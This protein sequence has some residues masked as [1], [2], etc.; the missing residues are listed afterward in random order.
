MTNSTVQPVLEVK[1]LKQ[2]FTSGFG[3]RKTVLKAVDDV[4][5]TIHKGETFGLVGESGCGKT[6]TG[7]TII[8]LYQ[9]TGGEIYFNGKLISGRLSKEARQE[10]TRGMQMIFQDPIASLNPRM[11]VKEIIGEGL[12]I[13]KLCKNEKEML[14]MVYDILETVGLTKEHASRYPHEFSGGQRQRI[15]IARALI[16]NPDL[17]IA[18]EPISA[19]DVSIQAQV[20]N[21]L[22]RLRKKLG[23]TI[24]F[25]AHDLSV[26]KYFSDRIGVMYNGKLVEL[27]NAD[28]L[29][30]RPLHPYT[31]SLLSA[32]PLPDPHHERNR[33]RIYYNPDIHD[34]KSERPELIEIRPGHFVYA[35]PSE[36]EAYRKKISL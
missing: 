30:T 35:S 13:N 18:D 11:T 19:L 10:V 4:S 24:L 31:Q 15:G 25:I 9:P 20:L 23:L 2:Y 36:A 22:N 12:K 17:I 5:F 6:T 27:A 1:N 21:L 29:Y 32:I 3:R 14:A 34:Y 33:K 28:E 16:T 26:V 8:R 7:R